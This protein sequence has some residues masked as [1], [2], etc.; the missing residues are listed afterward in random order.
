MKVKAVLHHR[1]VQALIVLVVWF[2]TATALKGVQTQ[3]LSTAT[4]SP[5][6]AMMRDAAAAIRG[7]RTESFLFVYVFN[8][9]RSVIS[10]LGGSSE[11]TSTRSSARPTGSGG[12]FPSIYC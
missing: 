8:P 9:I 3:E 6:T 2:V 7:N 12:C 5:F 4:D 1:W 10:V 11:T